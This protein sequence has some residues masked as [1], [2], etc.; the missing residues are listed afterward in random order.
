MLRRLLIAFLLLVVVAVLVVDRVGARAAAHVL[1]GQ[2]QSDEHLTERPSVSI[3]GI[4]FLTQVFGGKYD[5]VTVTAHNYKTSDG[6]TVTTLKAHL[7]GAHIPFSKVVN[8]SVKS[9][10]VDRVD[11]SAYLSFGNLTRFLSTQGLTVTLSRD[12]SRGINLTG[13]VPLG[14][15]VRLVHSVVTV[16]ASRSVVTLSGPARVHGTML[17]ISLPIPFGALPFR[18][19]VTSVTVGSN[20]IIGTGRAKHVTLGS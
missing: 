16:S 4:P 18:F 3:G 17:P 1:A 8:G 14:G 7:H 10:P 20:G 12:S 11:G 6:V 5:D 15:R 9:V 2:L 13:R 19:T